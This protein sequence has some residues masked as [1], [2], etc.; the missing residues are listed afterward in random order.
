MIEII[1]ENKKIEV[2]NWAKNVLSNTTEQLTS[3]ELEIRKRIFN[4]AENVLLSPYDPEVLAAENDILGAV[5]M[6]PDKLRQTALLTVLTSGSFYP[7]NKFVVP[8]TVV[9]MVNWD[10]VVDALSNFGNVTVYIRE[11]ESWYV[12]IPLFLHD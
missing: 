1:E 9:C 3:T 7:D 10:E 6:V 8:A 4:A 12:G 11:G 5:M 2:I